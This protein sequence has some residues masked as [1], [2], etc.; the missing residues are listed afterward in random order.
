VPTGVAHGTVTLIADGRPF[1][2]TTLRVDVKTHGR[3]ADVAFGGDWRQDAERRDLT[4]NGLYADENGD[5]I[6]L[7]GGLDDIESRTIRFIG[8]AEKRIRE[9]YL[10]I[11]RFFRFFAWYGDGRPDAEGLKACSRLKDGLANLSVERIWSEMRMLLSA[12]DPS[13]ALLWMRQ[14]GILSLAL[15]ESDKWGIDAIHG[16]INAERDLGWD[17]DPMLRLM[18]IVPPDEVRMTALAARLKMSKDEGFRLQSWAAQRP[19]ADDLPERRLREL[20]YRGTPQAI[21]DRMRLQLSAARRRA[22]SDDGALM[23]AAGLTRLLKLAD[24]WQRPEFPLRGRDLKRF[25]LVPG[26][27]MGRTLDRLEEA[28]IASDFTLDRA[29][30]L[31]KIEDV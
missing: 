14:T 8:E 17:V 22:E 12:P 29:A 16:L 21:R 27:E 5:V 9:D 15:P 30:L 28:W 4:I 20:L 18:A 24:S 7:V 6:D 11:L 2:V 25:G 10:R 26:P 23:E 3:H 1:E 31:A 19:L 13:R